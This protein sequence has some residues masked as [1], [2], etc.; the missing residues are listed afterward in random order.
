MGLNP[1]TGAS[2]DRQQ[3][4]NTLEYFATSYPKNTWYSGCACRPCS[5]DVTS[6][7]LVTYQTIHIFLGYPLKGPDPRIYCI[8]SLE[9]FEMGVCELPTN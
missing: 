3:L 6:A 8:A 2:Q 9:L 4:G 7:R 5:G 1:L